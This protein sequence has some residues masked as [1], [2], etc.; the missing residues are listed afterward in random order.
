MS[1]G[2][3]LVPPTLNGGFAN[4]R[5]LYDR[6]ADDM[7]ESSSEGTPVDPTISSSIDSAT[8][9]Q[10]SSIRQS[11][12][13]PPSCKVSTKKPRL[14]KDAIADS[15]MP[16]AWQERLLHNRYHATRFLHGAFIDHLDALKGNTAHDTARRSKVSPLEQVVTGESRER[17]SRR[18][19]VGVLQASDMNE[20]ATDTH[21]RN[22]NE[23]QDASGAGMTSHDCSST[24]DPPTEENTGSHTLSSFILVHHALT[25]M[26]RSRKMLK[27]PSLGSVVRLCIRWRSAPEAK[28]SHSQSSVPSTNVG[29]LGTR[30]PVGS[31]TCHS[32]TSGPKSGNLFQPTVQT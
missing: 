23:V 16:A 24:D 5:S 31:E 6:I 14:V 2:L 25:F 20:A 27:R 30:P 29:V 22:R 1:S 17:G 11:P 21:S 13:S 12:P 19:S 28:F 32:A 4:Y 3:P 18:G 26:Q 7:P 10:K 9:S 8:R 15:E